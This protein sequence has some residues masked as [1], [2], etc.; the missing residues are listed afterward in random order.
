MPKYV[1]RTGVMRA[2]GR[3]SSSRDDT[4]ARGSQVVV[5]SDRGMEVGEVLCEATDA[6]QAQLKD[7]PQGLR[8]G[9]SARLRIEPTSQSPQEQ[10]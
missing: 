2:L 9:L 7:A 4:Y 3:Y 8:P 6:A 10:L 1:V 5:R